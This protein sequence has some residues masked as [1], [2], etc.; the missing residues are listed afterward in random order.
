LNKFILGSGLVGLAARHILGPSYKIIPFKKSRF[1]SYDIPLADNTI[2]HH[3]SVEEFL[4]SLR[5][6]TSARYFSSAISFSGQ[7]MFNKNIWIET[8]ISKIYH[9]PPP[10][11]SKLLS[12]E[13]S[14]FHYTAKQLHDWLLAEYADE[15]KTNK[16]NKVDLIEE[17]AIVINGDKVDC[18]RIISTIPLNALLG[19]LRKDH[20][21]PS[22]DY[23]VFLVATNAFDLE[24]AERCFIGD[25]AI[26]F[27]KVNVISSNVY[28]F[29]ANEVVETAEVVFALL[30]GNK[31]NI[32]AQTVM[33]EAFPLGIPPTGMLEDL[34][35]MNITCVGSNAR[36]DYFYDVSTCLRKLLDLQL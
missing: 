3:D 8:V 15:I 14:V 22:A 26:P 31:F 7:L 35:Q 32:M 16:D 28:Q 36:W 21:L 23:N 9:E 30:T 19:L 20:D 18:D 11:A 17:G 2:V 13:Y 5:V 34:E 27:W 29:F 10:L 33:P 25:Q 1:F 24:G 12:A 6:P 4:K